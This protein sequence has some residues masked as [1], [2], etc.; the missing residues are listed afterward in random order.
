MSISSLHNF[1]SITETFKKLIQRVPKNEEEAKWI[2]ETVDE[3]LS[4][5]PQLSQYLEPDRGEYEAFLKE[6]ELSG[7]FN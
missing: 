6:L 3:M 1:E 5:Y 4:K 7:A 2:I